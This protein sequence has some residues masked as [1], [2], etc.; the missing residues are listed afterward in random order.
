MLGQP[1]E[2]AAATAPF[3]SAVGSCSRKEQGLLD[4]L[5]KN[6]GALPCLR[7]ARLNFTDMKSWIRSQ[8]GEVATFAVIGTL[9]LG[10][11]IFRICYCFF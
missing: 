9:S 4:G 5:G 11:R 7:R 2:R 3:S 6:F 1:A 10:Q 8:A